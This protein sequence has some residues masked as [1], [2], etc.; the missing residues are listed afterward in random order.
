[1]ETLPSSL[2]TAALAGCSSQQRSDADQNRI[3][4]ERQK[5]IEEQN[6]LILGEGN[7]MPRNQPRQV[8][9]HGQGAETESKA[10]GRQR[11]PDI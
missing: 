4:R 3:E 8:T 6:Q 7:S 1:V 10:I 9:G 11:K 2:I 5:A